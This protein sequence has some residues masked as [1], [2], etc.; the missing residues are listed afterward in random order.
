MRDAPLTAR[1]TPPEVICRSVE[2]YLRNI[3]LIDIGSRKKKPDPEVTR[4]SCISMQGRRGWAGHTRRLPDGSAKG[5]RCQR[6]A[7]GGSRQVPGTRASVGTDKKLGQD[8]AP[9]NSIAVDEIDHATSA[10]M[11]GEEAFRQQG[12]GMGR[13]CTCLEPGA[14]RVAVGQRRPWTRSEDEQ[15]DRR[16]EKRP[17]ASRKSG[18]GCGKGR[19]GVPAY[20]LRPLLPPFFLVVSW[21]MG[22]ASSILPILKPDLAM[23]LIAA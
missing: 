6:W 14:N 1:G 12:P 7:I 15:E 21:G 5:S 9:R 22:V 18:V 3:H 16:P 10:F 23:A 20:A 2:R 4:L 11:G 8:D 13:S 19:I 17:Q